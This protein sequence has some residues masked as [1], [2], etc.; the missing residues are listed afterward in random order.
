MFSSTSK[1]GEVVRTY[2]RRFV[3]VAKLSTLAAVVLVLLIGAAVY[4]VATTANRTSRIVAVDACL[5]LHAAERD[6]AFTDYVIGVGELA[7]QRVKVDTL[8][9]GGTL[10]LEDLAELD[11]LDRRLDNGEVRLRTAQATQLG[12]T[13]FA[14]NDPDGFLDDCKRQLPGGN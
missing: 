4:D 7:Q 12:K 5:E 11:R 3:T 9:A 2:D 13:E 6:A 10:T 8:A 14:V 1:R